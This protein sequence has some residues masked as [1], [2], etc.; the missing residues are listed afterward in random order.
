MT[1]TYLGPRAPEEMIKVHEV[2]CAAVEA[3]CSAVKAG[4]RCADVDRACREL[5][6]AAGYGE[7]FVHST[8]HAVG[9][10]IHE[11]PSL[12]VT[13]DTELEAGMVV[14]IEPGIY[15]PGIGGVRVED[16]LVVTD[17]GYEN[18]TSLPRGPELPH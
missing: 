17:D 18:L 16:L 10:E 14:T 2:V 15:L 8:G 9:L 5:I 12:T 4:A 11:G 7:R 13:A 3:G 1:R 6:E